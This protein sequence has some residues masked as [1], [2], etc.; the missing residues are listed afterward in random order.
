MLASRACRK[1]IMIGTAIGMKEMNEVVS[2]MAD[3][4]QPWNCP[5]GRP[6]LRHLFNLNLMTD[7]DTVQFNH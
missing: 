7:I 5:H 2:H 3:L 6:T 4:D 1:S